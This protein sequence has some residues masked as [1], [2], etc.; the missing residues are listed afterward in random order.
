MKNNVIAKLV[1]ASPLLLLFIHGSLY[2]RVGEIAASRGINFGLLIETP[3]DAHVPFVPLFV[4]AYLFVWFLPALLIIHLGRSTDWDPAPCGRLSVSLIA[5]M[6]GCYG[7]WILFPVH[8]DLRLDPALVAQ[9]GW[10]GE[11]VLFN[12]NGASEWNA[13]PSFHVAGPWFLYRAVRSAVPRM[14]WGFLVIVLAIA[15]STVL[16]R[17]HY[18]ADIAFGIAAAELAYHGAFK[19]LTKG[20]VLEQDYPTLGSQSQGR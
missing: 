12:Y 1:I 3:V 9:H 2:N 5:L 4:L 19:R 6:L 20:T 7:F 15:A 16:I 17:I 18:L 11:L 13:C 10:L 8:V 14:P